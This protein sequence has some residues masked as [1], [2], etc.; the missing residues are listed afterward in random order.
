MIAGDRSRTEQTMDESWPARRFSGVPRACPT[1]L[2]DHESKHGSAG[3]QAY[4]RLLLLV[5]EP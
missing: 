3:A 1:P 4:G 5:N 2:R